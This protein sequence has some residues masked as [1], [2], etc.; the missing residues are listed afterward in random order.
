MKGPYNQ[1]S[2]QMNLGQMIKKL[3]AILL[4]EK[5]D[6]LK[7]ALDFGYLYPSGIGSWRGAYEELAIRYGAADYIEGGKNEMKAT[8][9]L[10][11]LKGTVG[12]TFEGYKGGG[13]EMAESTPVWVGDHDE[14]HNT[15]VIDIVSIDFRIYIM[16]GYREYS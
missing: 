11:I 8:G 10:Q 7:M 1:R 9:F 14:A 16:T 5:D 2:D 13:F 6:D 12:K 4:V 3:E 15:A